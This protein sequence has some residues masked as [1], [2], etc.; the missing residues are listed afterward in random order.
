MTGC[1]T[2]YM[3]TPNENFSQKS[4]FSIQKYT[5]LDD[6]KIGT[7][8][9]PEVLLIHKCLQNN[10]K[11]TLIC[12]NELIEKEQTFYV[13]RES[14]WKPIKLAGR[15]NKV[16][17]RTIEIKENKELILYLDTSAVKLPL[18]SNIEIQ[19]SEIKNTL[20]I[21]IDVE[22]IEDKVTLTNSEGN[23]ILDYT[24]IK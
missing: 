9:N 6:G 18:T 17:K 14:D 20:V 13:S 1:N 5:I 24:I 23:I 16:E 8:G 2:N 19:K 12:L 7:G 4:M 10:N 22:K 11:K 3:I 21:K 15:A